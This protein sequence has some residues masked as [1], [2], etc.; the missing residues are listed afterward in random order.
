M[1][2]YL[3][4]GIFF[5]FMLSHGLSSST[6]T[7]DYLETFDGGGSPSNPAAPAPWN[8]GNWD[9]QV[10]VRSMDE[11]LG[12]LDPVQADHGPLCEAPG[13][14][15][16]TTHL[17]DSVDDTIYQCA[18]HM[19]T[20]FRADDYGLIALTPPVMV[21][22]SEGP[23]VIEFDISTLSDGSR[24]WFG[25][26]V[27]PFSEQ[28]P[29]PIVDWL[30]DLNGFGRNAIHFDF[31]QGVI[32]PVV[33]RDFV[34]VE[35]SDIYSGSCQWWDSWENYFTPSAQTRRTIR[36]TLEQTRVRV[37]LPEYGLVWDDMQIDPLTWNKG[38]VSFLHHSYTPFK[39]GNLPNTWHWDNVHI[40][41]A[42][43][44]T[45]IP[46]AARYYHAAN[47]VIDFPV[48][49]PEGAYLR[50][51]VIGAIPELSLDGGQNW[52]AI[53]QM[54]SEKMTEG[55][56]QFLHPIPPGTQQIEIR[57]VGTFPNWW[58]ESWV[59]KDIAIFASD[60][61]SSNSVPFMPLPAVVVLCIAI[62]MVGLRQYR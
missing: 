9:L 62:L 6:E 22:F 41:P 48:A 16:N 24:D 38:V 11:K 13:H 49:A 17:V 19:M 53:E 23:A 12:S 51:S 43:P 47:P 35:G 39:D 29:L 14:D 58:G 55:S 52:Q 61:Q 50:G 8:P 34:A 18:N 25:V 36:I 42:A 2:A 33:Y 27:Q 44:I 15:G 37:E 4:S 60:D 21:D 31:D 45:I 20:G 32:C 54:P 57:R 40:Q 1:D 3:K 7:I 56:Y 5:L 46:A 26:S 30:P 28:L 10:H 59:A